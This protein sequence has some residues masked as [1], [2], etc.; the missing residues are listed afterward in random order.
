MRCD[1]DGGQ[2]SLTVY[3]YPLRAGISYQLRATVGATCFFDLLHHGGA[4][5]GFDIFIRA[6]GISLAGF[7]IGNHFLEFR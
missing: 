4:I 3:A 5:G 7:H 6:I 2:L 1:W